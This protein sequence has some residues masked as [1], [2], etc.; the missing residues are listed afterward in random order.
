MEWSIFEFEEVG[1]GEYHVTILP[2]TTTLAGSNAG[3][4]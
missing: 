2:K 4:G 1:G 3:R